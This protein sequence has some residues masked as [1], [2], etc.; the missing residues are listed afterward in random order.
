[1]KYNP[2]TGAVSLNVSIAPLNSATYY[3]N[4][5]ALSLQNTGTFTNPSYRL[6]NWTTLGSSTD[7]TSRL[8]SNITWAEINMANF[9]I[10]G[11]GIDYEAGIA[12]C[13]NPDKYVMSNPLN[14]VY[15][16]ATATW[17]GSVIEVMSLKTGE[18]LWNKTIDETTYTPLVSLADK[19]KFAALM[20]D[21]GFMCWDLQS[22]NLLWRSEAM[23]Y[24]W[25][26]P[27]F[28]AYSVESAY[29]L[30]YREAYDGIYAFD[31]DDGS[32]VWKYEAPTPYEYETPY[33]DEN[34]TS[35]YSFNGAGMIADGKLYAY[36]TEHSATQPLTRGWGL[37]CIN[38]TTGEGIWNITGSMTPGAVADGYL[39]AGNSYDGYMYVFGKGQSE[40][41]VTAPDVAVSKGSAITIKGTVLDLSPAQP[42]TPCV[43]KESMT[44]QMEYLH[45][46]HPIDGIKGDAIKT[47]VPVTLTAIGSDGSYID[48]GTT[49][50]NGYYGTFSLAWTPPEEGTYEII[51]SFE[52]DDSYGSSGAA[53]A[54]T[55]G[56]AAAAAVPIEPE[57]T[58]PEPTEPE[59]TEPE[60][61]EPEPTEPEPTEPTE[62]EPTEPEPTEPAEA[63][64]ITI[65]VAIIAAVV[66]ACIIGIASFWA[67]R[68]RK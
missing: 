24:P 21:G 2:W 62:P 59:P 10:I 8:M 68:K 64:F 31:W 52:G 19:G 9:G 7:L 44:T 40:T 16:N 32:I 66:I 41:T 14:T 53:T 22:G 46:Q 54:V 6:I 30:I 63:P 33:I 51:A 47:G 58:E 13:I 36:N 67:L 20:S 27:G 50:T 34:S 56:P 23:V 37:H 1:M 60:P 15:N 55:V 17:V 28:G 25:S 26:E 38:A 5:Y 57:P 35:V 48:I 3:M 45:M 42:G 4:G 43:S 18:L 49:T 61:T 29:G 39:T 12:V 11:H 65:E